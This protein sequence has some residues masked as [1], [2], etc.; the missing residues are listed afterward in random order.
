MKVKGKAEGQIGRCDIELVPSRGVYI[1]RFIMSDFDLKVKKDGGRLDFLPAPVELA[2]IKR[3]IL[4]YNGRKYTVR[5]LRVTNFNTGKTMEFTLDGGIEGIG[6]VKTHGEGIFGDK[7][8]DIKG[9]YSLSALNIAR[10]LTDYEG[11]VDSRGHFTYRDEK[12][13]MDGEAEAAYFSIMEKFL[14]RRIAVEHEQCRVHATWV[15]GTADVAL[16]GLSF[17]GAPPFSQNQGQRQE[18]PLFGALSWTMS[19]SPIL[20]HTS[21]LPR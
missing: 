13:T 11:L 17:K 2:E 9:E 10:V 6:D 20:P 19:A 12:F 7:H 21:T 16:E 1:K 4:D 5:E 14:V 18:A 8:S 3:G 15:D